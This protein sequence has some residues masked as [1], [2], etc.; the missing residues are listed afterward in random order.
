MS[1]KWALVTGAS[2]GIGLAVAAVLAG[3]GWNLFLVSNQ[4]KALM[5]AAKQL[6]QQHAVQCQTAVV[7]LALVDAAAQVKQWTDSLGIEVAL[8]VNNAGM[9]LFSEVVET[10]DAKRQNIMQLH[11]NTPVE[12]CALYGAEMKKRR[13]GF[14]LN[15][16]SISAVMPYPGISLYG[17][18]KTFMRYFSR[19]LRAEMAHYGVAVTCLIPGATATGLYDPGKINIGLAKK[20]GVMQTPE[21]VAAKAIA[22]LQQNRA[23]C[24]PGWLNWLTVGLVPMVPTSL[25]VWIRRKTDVFE[26]GL[27]A[28]G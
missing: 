14:I 12:L 17:P 22:A 18:T 15:V 9:L 10:P 28:L 27:K 16:S 8:L 13:A 3:K 20:L 2:S 25:I 4:P 26:R 7:D 21:W 1:A 5:A 23:E 6:E 19:A 11:M 24:I